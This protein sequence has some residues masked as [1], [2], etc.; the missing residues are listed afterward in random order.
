MLLCSNEL[1]VVLAGIRGLSL[2]VRYRG[3]PRQHMLVLS[4]TGLDPSLPFDDQFCCDAQQRF[5]VAV[6]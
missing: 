2:N 6:W 4:I 5:H 1:F 3:Q